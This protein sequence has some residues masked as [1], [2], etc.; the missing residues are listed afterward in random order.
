MTYLIDTNVISE[1]HKGDRCNANVAAWYASIDIGE[2]FLSV[3][4]LGEIRKGVESVRRC[5][6]SKA[7]DIE[8]WLTLV[9]DAFA[10]RILPIDQPIADE[11]GR[12]VSR[13]W[14]PAVDGLLAATAHRHGLIMVTRNLKDFARTGVPFL[15]PFEPQP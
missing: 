5:S 2:I 8:R 7:V 4:V 6:P 15:N 1:L 11:W 12:L 13:V 14:V 3:L 9:A 10:R